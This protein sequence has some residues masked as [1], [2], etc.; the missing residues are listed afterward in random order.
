[1]TIEDDDARLRILGDAA[2]SKIRK[3]A[4]SELWSDCEY[5]KSVRRFTIE[6]NEWG[7]RNGIGHPQLQDAI[8]SIVASIFSMMEA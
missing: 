4:G 2:I 6:L 3:R 5:E 8:D 1:M 7:N